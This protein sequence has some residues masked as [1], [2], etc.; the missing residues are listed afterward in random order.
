MTTGQMTAGSGGVPL[1]DW[2]QSLVNS[3]RLAFPAT[4]GAQAAVEAV[5]PL[6]APGMANAARSLD[7]INKWVNQ[8]GVGGRSGRTVQ[9]ARPMLGNIPP[10]EA[11]VAER[12]ER[13]RLAASQAPARV[14]PGSL[15][16]PGPGMGAPAAIVTRP[17]IARAEETNRAYQQ[18]GGDISKNYWV[19]NP[20]IKAAA[21]SRPRAGQVGY[22]DGADIQAWAKAQIAKGPAGKAM[23]DRFMADQ[24]R[25]GLIRKPESAAVGA[26]GEQI[27]QASAAGVDLGQLAAGGA[28]EGGAQPMP[29]GSRSLTPDSIR[30]WGEEIFAGLPTPS[31][32]AGGVAD[33]KFDSPGGMGNIPTAPVDLRQAQAQ[34]AWGGPGA[35]N[36]LAP[37]I[38]NF[39]TSSQIRAMNLSGEQAL[40]EAKALQGAAT[41]PDLD[42]STSEPANPPEQSA[43][44]A[45]RNKY[46][47]TVQ[48]PNMYAGY[49][50]GGISGLWGNG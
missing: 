16:I 31:F 49:Q 43:E 33:M 28:Y 50:A 44:D 9:P 6:A 14:E 1:P 11:G 3:A 38:G 8:P 26:T 35:S 48:Q 19:A 2:R 42:A 47:R 24:E 10:S 27:R 13:Q 37:S 34:S 32:Q 20:E 46:I 4:W 41:T 22:S 23:V 30:R 5:R 18:A 25:R 21:E 29:E 12:L 15:V 36:D 45:W 7:P 40:G 17:E 39:H